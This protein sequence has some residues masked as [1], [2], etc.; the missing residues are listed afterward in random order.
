[1]TINGYD[2]LQSARVLAD[3]EKEKAK[4]IDNVAKAI[5]QLATAVANHNERS[6]S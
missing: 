3:A 5:M 6:E 1:L 2:L 4:A